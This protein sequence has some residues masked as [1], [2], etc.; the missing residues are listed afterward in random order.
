MVVFERDDRIDPVPMDQKPFVVAED[1]GFQDQRVIVGFIPVNML[2][3][4]ETIDRNLGKVGPEMDVEARDRLDGQIDIRAI[5][6]ELIPYGS[7]SLSVD[8]PKSGQ[9]L[10]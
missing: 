6:E 3:Q 1:P 4:I 8:P 9:L 2:R 10:A 7:T 5:D